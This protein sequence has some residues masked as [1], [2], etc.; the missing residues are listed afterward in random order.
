MY[1]YG[2]Y[3]I[4]RNH[5]NQLN[6]DYWYFRTYKFLVSFHCF[7]KIVSLRAEYVEE[8]RLKLTSQRRILRL[9]MVLLSPLKIAIYL[10]NLYRPN[11]S[12]LFT[13]I[14]I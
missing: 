11:K 12:N 13:Q 4:N 5:F 7:R 2:L 9:L 3:P 1:I 8:S 14:P 10:N 6:I